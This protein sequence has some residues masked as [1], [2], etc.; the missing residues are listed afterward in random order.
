MRHLVKLQF[1]L[2]NEKENK[3]YENNTFKFRLFPFKLP[4]VLSLAD[5]PAEILN[6]VFNDSTTQWTDNKDWNQYLHNLHIQ[7]RKQYITTLLK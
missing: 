2:S 6:I 1:S 4:Y 5:N 7:H 3:F